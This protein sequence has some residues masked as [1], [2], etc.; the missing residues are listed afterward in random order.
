M[1]T[2]IPLTPAYSLGG[3]PERALKAYEKAHAWRELFT[4]ASQLDQPKEAVTGWVDKVTDYLGSRGRHSEAAQI[5][6]DYGNDVD[7]AVEVLC[8]GA[9]F[10]E[11]NRLASRHSRGDLVGDVIHPALDEAHEVL[12]ETLEEMDGQLAKEVTRLAELHVIRVQDPGELVYTNRADQDNF[13]L[14][15]DEPELE[16]VDVATNA[17]TVA[18][19]FTRYTVAP[20]TVFSQST[21]M[22]GCVGFG[23][24]YL[25]QTN[26]SKHKPSRKRQAGRK[27]TV[28]EYDYLVASV[29]RL[30]KR[31]DDK[32]GALAQ[33]H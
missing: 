17:T 9:E 2:Q 27:G 15:D 4:L 6:I 25:R 21:H 24:S 11:A 10:A 31:V 1:S 12:T 33:C 19:A 13:Y 14:V 26:K 3:K 29:G 23:S 8:R 28:D 20:T 7:G 18:T 22:T 30:V 32:S 16:N 5:F